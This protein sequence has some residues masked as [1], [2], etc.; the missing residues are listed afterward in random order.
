M[1]KL[2][3]SPISTSPQNMRNL[4]NLRIIQYNYQHQ[5]YQHQTYQH[6][7]YQHQSYRGLQH[8]AL[9]YNVLPHQTHQQYVYTPQQEKSKTLWGEYYTQNVLQKVIQ[10]KWI[11]QDIL[12]Q[13][14]KIRLM[15][16]GFVSEQE[17]GLC[18]TLEETNLR[19]TAIRSCILVFE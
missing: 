2:F 9:Q 17:E 7:S 13:Q 19:N 8:Q 4:E 5:A 15:N 18:Q 10:A 3:Y 14:T 6:Q 12:L 11:L 16:T 1:N